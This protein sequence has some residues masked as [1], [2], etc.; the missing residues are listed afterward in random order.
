MTPQ[1]LLISLA[2]G[3]ALQRQNARLMVAESCTGGLVSSWLTEIA[4]SS[5]WFD[6]AVVS[7]ANAIKA[8]FLKVRPATLLV[9]GAVSRQ[10]ALEMAEGLRREH[11]K[12]LVAAGSHT[13]ATLVALSITG[14]AG[15]TGGSI[16]KPLG[17]VHF[18]WAGPW[19]LE[20]DQALLTGSRAEI[21]EKAAR[22]A[23][24]G[25]FSR[26]SS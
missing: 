10:T 8:E 13:S 24:S 1:S 22:L 11:K 20:A 19:G 17:L 21:R 6:G 9:Q 26:L 18:G 5:H 14:V 7:Y 4:G 12:A 2:V 25:L 15:P 3:F 23:L 16:E